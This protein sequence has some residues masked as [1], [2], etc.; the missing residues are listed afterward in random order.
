MVENPLTDATEV[1]FGEEKWAIKG[2]PSTHIH[3]P[4]LHPFL[5]DVIFEGFIRVYKQNVIMLAKYQN[6]I[7]IQEKQGNQADVN[8]VTCFMADSF[9]KWFLKVIR[10]ISSNKG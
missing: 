8:K 4:L 6:T 5:Y 9:A 1:I 3:Q 2:E 7:H 10:I